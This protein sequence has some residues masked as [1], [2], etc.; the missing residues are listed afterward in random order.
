MDSISKTLAL[1]IIA[2]GSLGA[3]CA[4]EAAPGN[5]SITAATLSADLHVLAA[6]EMRGRLVGTPEISR[7]GDWIRTR[8]EQLGLEPAGTAGFDQPFDLVW[9]SLGEGNQL[10]VAGP[11][12]DGRPLQPGDGYY[13]L[14]VSASA[15]AA[16]PLAFAG[17]G[18]VEPRLAY[19]DYRTGNAAGKIVLVLEREPGVVDP[20]SP[21]DGVVTAESSAAWR[22]ALA[23]QEHGAAAILF[24]RDV[25]NRP[26]SGDY[27]AAMRATWPAEPRRIERFSLGVWM[28]RIHIPAAQVSAALAERLVAGSGH[29]LQEL[30]ASAETTEGLG[31]IDLPGPTVSLTAQLVRHATPGRNIIAKIEGMD[32]AMRDEAV[33]ISAHYDHNGADGEEI[34]N[35][36]DDDG[37]G[38]VGLLSIAAA[39][40]DAANSGR[41]PERSV[42]FAA[43]DAE[44]RGLLGAWYYTESP[45]YPLEQ[46]AAVLNMDMIGRN[47]EVPADGGGRFRGLEVQSA[48][49]NANAINIL[50]RNYTADLASA[51]EAANA[52]YGLELKFR[53]DNNESNLLRRSD[54]WPFLQRGVP[55]LWFHTGLH[56]DYHT[57]MDDADRIEYDKMERI[58]RLVHRTSWDLA[59][60]ATRPAMNAP[61][62]RPVGLMLAARVAGLLASART[63]GR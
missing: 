36:A 25:H 4:G 50:G 44:E 56:P 54:H 27:Q 62:V 6:D 3:A 7:A 1:L 15:A 5:R 19:D 28:D 41:R 29:T 47:E 16:G 46:T 13:P 18:I 37:S 49:S 9:F 53:Y 51:V 39:Y 10:T 48:E 30:A 45:S 20:A 32:P 34:F 31:V 52:D 2:T 59:N 38:I 11:G 55:A 63:G 21:F 24:V 14:N 23:A 40:A 17:F 43:W 35:G 22:K 61:P 8:F 58:A 42:V 33:I 12:F 57:A 60:A 26:D